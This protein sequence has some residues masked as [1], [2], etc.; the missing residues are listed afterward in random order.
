MNCIKY[1][2]TKRNILNIKYNN[3]NIIIFIIFFILIISGESK[4]NITKLNLYFEIMIR[5]K[6]NG[7]QQ[8]LSEKS[9]SLP[10]EIIVNDN[11]SIT[12]ISK[13][14]YNL[15]LEENVIKLFFNQSVIDCGFMFFRLTNITEINFIKFN[16]S[17]NNTE[18]MF[19]NCSNLISLDLSNF[20]TSS[21][22]Y[23]NYMFYG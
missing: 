21:V 14:I 15:T 8:I 23:M 22:I 19:Y 10:S 17:S 7:T 9:N 4:N 3:F 18:R 20:D 13:T 6:G 5:I 12:E 2:K 11:V 1:R 16:A